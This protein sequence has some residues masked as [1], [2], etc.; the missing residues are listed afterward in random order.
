MASKLTIEAKRF[1]VTQTEP[2]DKLSD[3]LQRVLIRRGF[4]NMHG[5]LVDAGLTMR[6]EMI[7][8][9]RNSP[10]DTSKRSK[11]RKTGT[12]A[13]RFHNPSFPGNPPR[14]IS[15]GRGGLMG[16]LLV[17]EDELKGEVRVGSIITDPP[18]PAFLEEGTDRMEARPWAEPVYARHRRRIKNDVLDSLKKTARE[19]ARGR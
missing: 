13:Q 17:D 18:Y 19:F 7:L 8:G 11:V 9:M 1:G 10:P 16:S 14:P 12:R 15:G 4:K 2:F 5:V 6:N 3:R